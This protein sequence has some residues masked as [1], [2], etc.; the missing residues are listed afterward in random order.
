MTGQSI[1]SPL[2]APFL[3]PAFSLMAHLMILCQ[4]TD[5]LAVRH[6]CP[7]A[8]LSPVTVHTSGVV[9]QSVRQ[10]VS[11]LTLTVFSRGLIRRIS[12]P[13]DRQCCSSGPSRL[14]CVW[15]QYSATPLAAVPCLSSSVHLSSL[16]V[17]ITHCTDP[18]AAP[19]VRTLALACPTHRMV[20]TTCT[21]RASTGRTVPFSPRRERESHCFSPC[22]R[23]SGQ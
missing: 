9:L 19:P 6:E 4:S 13:V 11:L 12:L 5:W 23:Y 20:G 22:A 7:F 1:G 21:L 10:S 2:F 16:C 18:P 17:C 15:S 3:L 8:Q 14:V